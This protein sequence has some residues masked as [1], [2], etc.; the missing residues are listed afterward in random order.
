MQRIAAVALSA[1]A[2]SACLQFTEW[3][4]RVLLSMGRDA[5]NLRSS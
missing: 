3:C 1:P 2:Q 4:W 5:E